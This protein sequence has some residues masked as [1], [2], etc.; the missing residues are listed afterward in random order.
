[1]RSIHDVARSPSEVLATHVAEAKIEDALF[2]MGTGVSFDHAA[3]RV[4]MTPGA[5]ERAMERHPAACRN[6]KPG[7][8]S[9]TSG[10]GE[11]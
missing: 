7:H 1:M 11:G 8:M 6:A 4:G 10:H 3:A 9:D 5:L 2:L